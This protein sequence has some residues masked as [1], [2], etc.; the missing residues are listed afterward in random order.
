MQFSAISRITSKKKIFF[1]NK[2]HTEVFVKDYLE[3][4]KIITHIDVHGY[5]TIENDR[6][7][8]ER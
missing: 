2:Q 3:C 5:K 6:P 4:E 1:I 7:R 8:Y